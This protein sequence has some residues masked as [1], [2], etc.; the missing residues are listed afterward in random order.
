MTEVHPEFFPDRGLWLA[1]GASAPTIRELVAKLPPGTTVRDYFPEGRAVSA[2]ER[3]YVVNDLRRQQDLRP[4]VPT[5]TGTPAYF[6][7]RRAQR[8]QAELPR[9]VRDPAP[10]RD[11]T[12]RRNHSLASQKYDHDRVLDLWRA[13]W[14]GPEIEA[15]LEM[16]RGTAV[17]MVQVERQSGEPRAV[18]QISREWLD[19]RAARGEEFSAVRR[20]RSYVAP[21]P[22]VSSGEISLYFNRELFA[23]LDSAARECG[24][25]RTSLARLLVEAGARDPATC[26]RVVAEARRAR[27]L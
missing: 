6:Q 10:C 22:G 9:Q 1:D 3:G 17:P 12:G 19:A 2:A 23:L 7:M 15:E 14:T 4:K 5:K 11:V 27:P 8:V 18:K 21:L 24:V 16:P 26:A 13:G 25:A 20:V